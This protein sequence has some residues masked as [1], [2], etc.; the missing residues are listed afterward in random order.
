MPTAF[1]AF[2]PDDRTYSVS[3]SYFAYGLGNG[4]YFPF[5][6]GA[7]TVFDPEKP[8]P[9]RTAA[10]LAR[11]RPT[12]F[13]AVP[14]FYAALLKEA[15]RGLAV[16][17]SS[18]R[19]AVSAGER[20]PPEIFERFK[21]RFRIWKSW[22]ASAQPKCCTCFFPRSPVT[23]GQGAAVFPSPATKRRSWTKKAPLVPRGE[24]GNLWVKRPKRFFG[25]LGNS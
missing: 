10:L 14:T 12:I 8:R 16:D 3:K 13:F 11:H 19:L 17:F 1:S 23:C 7:A 4:M 24:I 22:T 5:S 18:V 2:A 15:E 21:S 20:L 25:I 9:E 6:V